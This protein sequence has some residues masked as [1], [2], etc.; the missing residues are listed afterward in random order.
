MFRKSFEKQK[1][2]LPIRI[3]TKKIKKV[4]LIKITK[5]CPGGFHSWVKSNI[6]IIRKPNSSIKIWRPWYLK[7]LDMFRVFKGRIK[8]QK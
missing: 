1:F 3:G 2:K 7:L 8:K 5:T 6:G 4:K